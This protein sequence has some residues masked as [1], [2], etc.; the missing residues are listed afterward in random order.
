M[1]FEEAL[2][3]VVGDEG[4]YS[5][6]ANDHGGETRFGITLQTARDYGYQGDMHDLPFSTAVAIYK[7]NYWDFNSLDTIDVISSHLSLELFNIGVN[8]APSRAAAWLQRALNA[9]NKQGTIYRDIIADG[10][11][12]DQTIAALNGFFAYRGRE[13]VDKV[14]PRAIGCLQGEHYIAIAEHDP[15]QEDFTYG[16]IRNRVEI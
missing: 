10:V 7:Q 13:G 9:F 4:D 8:L 12:G 6:E 14:L 5:N 1:S 16:W 11:M 15:T 3:A 2:T